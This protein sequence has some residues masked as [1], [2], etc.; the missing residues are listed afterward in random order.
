[1]TINPQPSN[2]FGGIGPE[3]MLPPTFGSVDDFRKYMR[4]S[5]GS[6][7]AVGS[8]EEQEMLRAFK[9]SQRSRSN[10]AGSI[11]EELTAADGGKDI[12]RRGAGRPDSYI[13]RH[14]S[15]IPK[16]QIA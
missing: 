7:V 6:P 5:A 13:R 4:T 3:S 8:E 12:R 1:M 11:A 10:R 15:G 2:R 9:A 14:G 16:R